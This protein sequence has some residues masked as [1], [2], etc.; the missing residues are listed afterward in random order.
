MVL[1]VDS[2]SRTECEE[3]LIVLKMSKI[4]DHSKD[5]QRKYVCVHLM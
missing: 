2:K 4:Q 3:P 1:V 5:L